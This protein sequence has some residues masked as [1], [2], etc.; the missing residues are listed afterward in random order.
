MPDAPP[1]LLRTNVSEHY[2]LALQQ[3]RIEALPEEM[4]LRLGKLMLK[5]WTFSLVGSELDKYDQFNDIWALSLPDHPWPAL[6]SLEAQI[7]IAEKVEA[8]SK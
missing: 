7:K 4:R 6:N 1:P 3:A 2:N 8:H 5:G